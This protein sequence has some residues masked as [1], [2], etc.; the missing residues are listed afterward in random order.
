MVSVNLVLPACSGITS[1]DIRT[2]CSLIGV[3]SLG[4]RRNTPDCVQG[5]ETVR[6]K[7]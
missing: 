4:G 1:R 7:A 2:D 3:S 5:V 6:T